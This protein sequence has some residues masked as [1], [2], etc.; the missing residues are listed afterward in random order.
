MPA[1]SMTAAGVS[2]ARAVAAPTIQAADRVIAPTVAS[3][4]R[5]SRRAMGKGIPL[6]RPM[7][8]KNPEMKPLTRLSRLGETVA[9]AT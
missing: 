8:Y 4:A 2:A 7:G 6:K 5:K 3:V 9:Q 1:A